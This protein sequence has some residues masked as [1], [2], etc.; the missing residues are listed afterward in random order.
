MILIEVE[1]SKLEYRVMEM[2]VGWWVIRI[3]IGVSVC[4]LGKCRILI[5]S[6]SRL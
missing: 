6:D 1:V 5:E 4:D 2:L 3:S